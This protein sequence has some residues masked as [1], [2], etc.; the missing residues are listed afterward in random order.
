MKVSPTVVGWTQ[1]HAIRAV[2]KK[3]RGGDQS[4][5]DQTHYLIAFLTN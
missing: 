4:Q 3:K 5:L 1:D 2:G